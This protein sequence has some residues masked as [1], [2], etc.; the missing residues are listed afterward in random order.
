MKVY[1]LKIQLE[2]NYIKPPIWRRILVKS[3]ISFMDL[4]KIIQV[5]MG[6]ENAHLWS[7]DYENYS[8]SKPSKFD[9]FGDTIDANTIKLSEV[10]KKVKSKISYTYDFGDGWDHIITLEKILEVVDINQKLP[11][12]IKGKRACPPEDCGGV[13][14]YQNLLDIISNKK[15]PEHDEMIAWLGGGFDPEEFE[16]D[17]INDCLHDKGCWEGLGSF[18]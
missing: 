1:Q 16:I 4:H 10:L 15:H 14:G 7:F 5:T 13:W 11:T 2:P 18:F 6:W 17:D 12:C 8:I 3:N 9:T